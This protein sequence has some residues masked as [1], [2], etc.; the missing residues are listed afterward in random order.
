[1]FAIDSGV[2]SPYVSNLFPR[3]GEDVRIRIF[4]SR[5]VS[6]VNARLQILR[7][8]RIESFEMSREGDFM[9]A[10]VVADCDLL[11]WWFEV[12][13]AGSR[14]DE[15]LYMT[16]D[17]IQ[18]EVPVFSQCFSLVVGMD[19]PSWVSKSTCYQ[20]FPDRFCKGDLSLGVKDGDYSFD[21]AVTHEMKWT[22]RPLQF[23]QGHCLDFFNG[24]L[25]GIIDRIPYLMELGISCVYL[26]PIGCSMTTHRYDCTDFFHVDPKLG[27]DEAFRRLCDALHENGI[28]IIVD[29]SINHTGTQNKWFQSALKGGKEREYYFFDEEGNAACWQN[30][31][32]LPQLNY[33]SD[34]LREKIY[35]GRESVMR[36]FLMPP[37]C[38]DGW[39]LDVADELG[40]RPDQYL[41]QEVWTEVNKAVKET[42]PNAYL[43]AEDWQDSTPFLNGHMWDGTMNYLGSSRPLLRW[44]GEMDRF[45]LPGWGHVPQQ[46]RPYTGS[47][48]RKALQL[49]LSSLHGQFQ[50]LQFN[51]LDSHDTFRFHNDKAV[52]DEDVYLGIL[53]ALF[54]LPGMP[55]IYYGDEILLEGP[56]GSVED[57][58]FPMDWNPERRNCRTF[59]TVCELGRLRKEHEKV[60]SFGQ[61]SFLSESDDTLV[62]ARYDEQEALVLILNKD[63]E[64]K[65]VVLDFFQEG[66]QYLDFLSGKEVKGS[67]HLEPRQSTVLILK[68][69]LSFL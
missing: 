3:H 63:P 37:Y 56:T 24:D 43:V 38:Q 54:L 27:G 35:R 30:V 44:A 28:R 18:S 64:P 8:N 9:S 61:T 67:L 53:C 42:N 49:Q 23:E 20:I 33:N 59:H 34:T 68:K 5:K 26:N 17:G 11:Q 65:Q 22:D 45:Q 41:C 21:G 19:D 1:M 10:V 32:T 7:N 62:M 4:V 31:P 60:I 29:I 6:V 57:S 55:S 40:V 66:K 14:F 16:K 52:F 46:T 15:I 36:K 48:L 13:T 39:R 51:L 12:R 50:Y 58:R 69:P 25:K 2:S 47:E